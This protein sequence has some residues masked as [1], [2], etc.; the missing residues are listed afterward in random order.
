M[1]WLKIFSWQS[2]DG[3]FIIYLSQ[4]MKYWYFFTYASSVGSDEPAL[5]YSLARANTQGDIDEGSD[6]ILHL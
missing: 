2:T 4:Y 3:C 1:S 5:S 6:Q